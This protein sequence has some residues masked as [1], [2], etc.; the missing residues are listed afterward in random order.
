M[1]NFFK[2]LLLLKN[3]RII[4]DIM[5][6]ISTIFSVFFF[7]IAAFILSS[8][9]GGSDEY[10]VSESTQIFMG[11]LEHTAPSLLPIFEHPAFRYVL[12]DRNGSFIAYLDLS[13]VM[14]S[15]MEP[16]IDRYVNISG[17]MSETKDGRVIKAFN[18]RLS[19]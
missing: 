19:R 11:K 8:C 7:A 15:N 5:K 10:R 16:L 17:V 4:E 2:I 12:Y 6:K 18:L 1:L 9:A 3:I 13:G 14:I